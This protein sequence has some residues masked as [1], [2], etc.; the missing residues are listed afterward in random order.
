MEFGY[1]VLC[2]IGIYV[3]YRI[4]HYFIR[5]YPKVKAT[6]KA[7]QEEHELIIQTLNGFNISDEKARMLTL[8]KDSLPAGYRC[9]RRLCDGVLLK[10]TPSD[11]YYVCSECGNVRRMIRNAKRVS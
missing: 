6:R 4:I 1:L 3:L 5:D 11:N 9:G 2:G 7:A 10:R 8:L